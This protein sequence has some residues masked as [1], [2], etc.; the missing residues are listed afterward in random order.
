LARGGAV[1]VKVSKPGQ[2]L[3]FDVPA[4]G[5]NTVAVCHAAG[6]AVLALEAGKTLLL[7]R[8]TLLQAANETGLTIVGASKD[9]S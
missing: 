4:I 1:A 6:I 3:R 5:P 8:K 7:E 9:V 2:D